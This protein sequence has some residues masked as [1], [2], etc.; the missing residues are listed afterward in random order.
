M[1]IRGPLISCIPLIFKSLRTESKIPSLR[2]LRLCASKSRP[3]KYFHFF[4]EFP[5]LLWYHAIVKNACRTFCPRLCQGCGGN[6]PHFALTLA[7]NLWPLDRHSLLGD[8][9]SAFA[10]FHPS[11]VCRCGDIE[12]GCDEPQK[13][14]NFDAKNCTL[15]QAIAPYRTLSHFKKTRAGSRWG[16]A[17]KV[18]NECCE[19]PKPSKSPKMPDSGVLQS[20]LIAPGTSQYKLIALCV[21]LR[22]RR[23]IRRASDQGPIGLNVSKCERFL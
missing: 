16:Q 22:I 3:K 8:G 23:Q 4:I 2:P 7:F 21:F 15:S 6:L 11:V 1:L 12:P 14:D 17:G 10:L 19:P 20:R 5:I 13:T 9:G 18:E